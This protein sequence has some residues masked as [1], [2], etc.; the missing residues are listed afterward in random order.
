MLPIFISQQKVLT[1]S[2]IFI[3]FSENTLKISL[4]TFSIFPHF[5]PCFLPIIFF[6][7]IF[8]D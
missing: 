3:Y 1:F 7:F 2:I 5:S 8:H 4:R 6:T